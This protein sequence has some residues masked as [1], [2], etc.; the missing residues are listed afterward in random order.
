MGVLNTFG[1]TEPLW[2]VDNLPIYEGD[3]HYS[4]RLEIYALPNKYSIINSKDIESTSVLKDASAS[5][6]GL[7]AS[8]GMIFRIKFFA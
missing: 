3:P 1:Y 5:I 7:K 2:L 6:Y 8:N 4:R